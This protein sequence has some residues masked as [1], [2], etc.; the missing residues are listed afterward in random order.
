[1]TEQVLPL[2]E[3]YYYELISFFVSSAFLLCHA[4]QD[5]RYYPSLRLMDGA[6]RLTKYLIQSGAFEDEAWPHE[7]VERCESGLNLLMSDEEAFVAFITESTRMLAEQM[8]AR[9]VPG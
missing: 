7:F 6:S 4:E 2:D 1:M 8:K 9:A 3:E 5:D